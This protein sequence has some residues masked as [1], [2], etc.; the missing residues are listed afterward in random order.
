MGKRFKR[1]SAAMSTSPVGEVVRSAYP[2]TGAPCIGRPS[3]LSS[4]PC[5]GS[6]ST[7]GQTISRG[8]IE[9]LRNWFAKW[10]RREL[11]TISDHMCDTRLNEPAPLATLPNVRN[12][13]ESRDW[14]DQPLSAEIQP[15]RATTIAIESRVI[16]RGRER[17][18]VPLCGGPL[19]RK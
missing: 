6:R 1:L 10:I 3:F 11:H 7:N 13:S 4:R 2:L 18:N 9:T 17:G 14:S 12:G 5:A 19:V 15:P 16:N 8:R